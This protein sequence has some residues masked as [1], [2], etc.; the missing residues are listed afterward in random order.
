[1]NEMKWIS[2]EESLPKPYKGVIIARVY[3]KGEPLRVEAGMLESHGWW[4]VYGANV[5][6]GV[7]YWMPLPEP[8]EEW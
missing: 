5:K 7:L 8:P 4:K 3:E 6:K 2:T 1:M